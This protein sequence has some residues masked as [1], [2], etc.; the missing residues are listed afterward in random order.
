[1]HLLDNLN[2]KLDSIKMHGA[3]VK[4]VKIDRIKL[5]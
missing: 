1:M 5:A 4:I 3:T 2:N